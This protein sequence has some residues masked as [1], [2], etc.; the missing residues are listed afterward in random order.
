MV[1]KSIPTPSGDNHDYLSISRYWWPNPDTPNELPWIRKDGR[2]NPY[3]QTDAADRKRLGTMTRGVEKLSLA[4]YFS[5][6]ERYAQKAISLIFTWFINEETRMNPHLEFAQSVPGRPNKRPFGILDGRSIPRVI[7]DAMKLLTTSSYWTPD[8]EQNMIEWFTQYLQWLTKSD[9]GKMG[10][11]LEN[12]HGSWYKFQVASIALY[13]G[14]T[15]LVKRM[16]N[17]AQKSLNHQLN[18][19]GGQTRELARTQSFSYSCFNLV[20]LTNIAILADKV[21]IN[22]WDFESEEGKSLSL[23]INYLTP[24]IEGKSWSHPS[25]KGP[26]LSKLVPILAR[27]SKNSTSNEFQKPL[28]KALKILLEKEQL[29]NKN[30]DILQELTLVNGIEF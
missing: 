11:E 29:S 23:A 15:N 12:N 28:F 18:P 5:E 16:I 14:D 6:D 4:Y 9:L 13:L 2:T 26:N 27:F 1:N 10:L 22:M 17:L 30:R 3:T 19:E 7:P 25:M 8:Y 21:G 20:A 24:V